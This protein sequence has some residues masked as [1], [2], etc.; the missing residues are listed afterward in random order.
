MAKAMTNPSAKGFNHFRTVT[1]QDQSLRP[2]IVSAAQDQRSSPKEK[3]LLLRILHSYEKQDSQQPLTPEDFVLSPHEI[4]ELNTLE[5]S[6][7][8]KYLCYRYSYNIF[9]L[10]HVTADYPPC[11]QIELSSVCNYRCTMCFQVDPSFSHRNHGHMGLMTLDMYKN[12]IDQIE[13][14]IEGVTL[15][16]RG[17]PTL[18]KAFIQMIEYSADKFLGFKIN[19]NASQLTEDKC[20][21]I[22]GNM[23]RG[24]IVFSL[25]TTDPDTYKKIRVN[26]TLGNVLHNV[27]RFKEIRDECYP[28]SH[29]ITRVSGVQM[30]LTSSIEDMESYW[31]PYVDQVSFVPCAPWTSLYEGLQPNEVT[32]PCSDLWRRM[33]VWWDGKVNPCDYDYKSMLSAGDLETGSVSSLW[34][35]EAYDNLRQRHMSKNRSTV[36]PC[37]QCPSV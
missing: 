5:P 21:A 20:H 28:N 10:L 15:A 8:G 2:K 25:E 24:T 4:A 19:T 11:I 31:T 32:A 14:N 3:E 9:P 30:P 37:R 6:E 36:T 16:S 33:F 27:K 17:E 23:N 26:G 18:N 34:N 1:E 13:G 29:I 7:V 22:L 35:S 12:I